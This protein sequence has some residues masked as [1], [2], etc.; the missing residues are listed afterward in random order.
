MGPEPVGVNDQGGLVRRS[1]GLAMQPAQEMI[2]VWQRELDSLSPAPP[3]RLPARGSGP[4]LDGESLKIRVPGPA[5]G[6]EG[7]KPRDGEELARRHRQNFIQPSPM[8]MPCFTRIRGYP[9]MKQAGPPGGEGETTVTEPLPTMLSHER[10]QRLRQLAGRASGQPAP[11]P[12]RAVEARALPLANGGRVQLGSASQTTSEPTLKAH[13][14]LAIASADGRLGGMVAARLRPARDLELAAAAGLAVEGAAR[15][16][17]A[18]RLVLA[19]GVMGAQG[20]LL[21]EAAARIRA[22]V[23]G[24]VTIGPE[25]RVSGLTSGEGVAIARAAA[26]GEIVSTARNLSAR[27]T[28]VA[29]A[30]VGVHDV[31]AAQVQISQALDVRAAVEGEAAVGTRHRA[32]GRFHVGMDSL[33][34]PSFGVGAGLDTSSGAWTKTQGAGEVSLLGLVRVGLKGRLEA[35]AGLGAGADARIDVRDG[36]ISVGLGGK[37][38][39]GVGGGAGVDVTVGLGKLP[40]GI[41]QTLGAPILPIPGLLLNT[42]VRGIRSLF[43]GRDGAPEDERPTLVDFPEVVGQ[44]LKQGVDRIGEGLSDAGNGVVSIARAVV[45][46]V[47]AVGQGIGDGIGA[48]FKGIGNLFGGPKDEKPSAPQLLDADL[49]GKPLESL[50]PDVAGAL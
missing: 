24:T 30:L 11:R 7:G 12:E 10:S 32:D 16:L 28:A 37:A 45:G 15:A 46:G 8:I 39:A 22:T 23:A 43:G 21:A 48:I 1:T 31:T 19:P 41:L 5:A 9:P 38:A 18:D 14:G 47:A 33:G 35:L 40:V 42:A 29:E 26:E 36:A 6:Q 3:L 20:M 49:P 4:E 50:E 27:G 34:L 13:E 17:A 44:N 2:P 25:I